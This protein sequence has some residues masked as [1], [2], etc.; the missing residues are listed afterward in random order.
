MIN[1]DIPPPRILV[2]RLVEATLK[3]QNHRYAVARGVRRAREGFSALY[4]RCFGVP[5]DPDT[6]VCVTFGTK[7]AINTL[8]SLFASGASYRSDRSNYVPVTLLL[9]LPT[10]PGF[11]FAAHSAGLS[12]SYYKA[13]GSED[14]I[15]AS[16][17][18]AIKYYPFSVL[19]LN[20]PNNPTG[21]TVSADFYRRLG[22]LL[23]STNVTVVNDFVYGEMGGGV[24]VLSEQSL[25]YRSVETYSLSKAYSVPGWRIGAVMGVP[26][27]VK[28][29]ARLKSAM[30]Y[31]LFL[32]LQLAAGIVLSSGELV[33][34]PVIKEYRS[35][36]KILSDLLNSG[37]WEAPKFNIIGESDSS[38]GVSSC[39]S[40][41]AKLPERWRHLGSR[42]FAE[43]A[44][45]HGIVVTPGCAFSNSSVTNGSLPLGSE[46]CNSKSGLAGAIVGDL[47]SSRNVYDQYVRF[48]LVVKEE[49]LRSVGI[50]LN[51]LE[52]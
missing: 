29:V 13:D 49:K 7:D 48:A 4:Q 17:G 32:P 26:T 21:L 45:N 5:L 43:K 37:G 14:S 6:E 1:P 16:I 11:I 41:W 39:S 38:F 36:A 12:V 10:Y 24:S 40:I 47:D 25:R 18:E 30:D 22:V 52:L 42:Y 15:L 34:Q 20:Y 3:V 2:D 46:V 28:A 35:R 33:A 8:F 9:P 23:E 44:L 51:S 31:G 19:V 27:L 50:L